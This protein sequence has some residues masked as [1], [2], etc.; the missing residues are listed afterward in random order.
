MR[1]SEN[2]DDAVRGN[3]VEQEVT[4]IANAVLLRNEASS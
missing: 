3:A 2:L 1:E 4:R